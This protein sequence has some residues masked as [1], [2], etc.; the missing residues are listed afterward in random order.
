MAMLSKSG[1]VAP[2]TRTRSGPLTC[3]SRERKSCALPVAPIAP[4]ACAIPYCDAKTLTVGTLRSTVVRPA[5]VE[6]M[7]EWVQVK[8]HPVF[9]CLILIRRDG[10]SGEA[11][12]TCHSP[13][14]SV[15]FVGAHAGPGRYSI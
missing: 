13:L 14:Q 4:I 11:F 2:A 15:T 5:N 8:S 3:S 6:G 7:V 12:I 1:S 9:L 10:Q